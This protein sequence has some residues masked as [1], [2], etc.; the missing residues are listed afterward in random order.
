M[1]NR[2][3]LILLSLLFLIILKCAKRVSPTGGPR[4]SLP[5][6]LINSSPKLNTTFFDKEGFTLTFDEPVTI[7]AFASSLEALSLTQGASI[8]RIKGIVNTLDRPGIPLIIHGVQ[9]VFHD[10]V[11]LDEW[12]DKDHQTKLVF[13]TKGIER[14]TLNLF[15]KAWISSSKG[16]WQ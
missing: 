6:R 5:P 1:K 12:P 2:K 8:L 13:I 7:E 9:H 15:F 10:P 4:D 11:W 14:E 16:S 3:F